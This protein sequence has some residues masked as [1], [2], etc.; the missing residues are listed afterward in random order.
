M[1]EYAL[2]AGLITVAVAASFPPVG[3]GLADIFSK[4]GSLLSQSAA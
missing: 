2:L 3:T 4:L 1:V